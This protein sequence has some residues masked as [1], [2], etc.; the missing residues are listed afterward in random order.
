MA[1]RARSKAVYYHD[2][3]ANGSCTSW[4]CG[5]ASKLPASFN[6]NTLTSQAHASI[7]DNSAGPQPPLITFHPSFTIHSALSAVSR[8]IIV[9]GSQ[10]S[11]AQKFV[12][13]VVLR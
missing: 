8:L 12:H 11:A 5:R 10:Y 7:G 2:N 13:S 1:N 4:E 6:D 9:M 3:R